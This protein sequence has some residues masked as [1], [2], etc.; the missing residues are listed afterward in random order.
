MDDG[1]VEVLAEGEESAVARLLQ[2]LVDGGPRHARIEH[3]VT[4][5]RPRQHFSAFTIRY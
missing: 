1:R 5:P 3:V 4:E 2:W